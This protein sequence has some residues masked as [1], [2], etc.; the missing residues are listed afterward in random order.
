M[1]MTEQIN[2]ALIGCGKVGDTHAQAL[3]SLP[4]SRFV[5]VYYS[6]NEKERID[7]TIQSRYHRFR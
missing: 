4:E 2:T 3:A 6:L 1:K 5:A 7:V